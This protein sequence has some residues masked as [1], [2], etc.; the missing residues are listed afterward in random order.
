MSELTAITQAADLT[1]RFP[2]QIKSDTRQGFQG[3]IV[4]PSFLLEFARIL[5]DEEGYDYL[6][7]LTGVDSLP[8]GQMEVV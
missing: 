1:G 6:S 2:E 4:E 7:S 3:L 8:D 5:R